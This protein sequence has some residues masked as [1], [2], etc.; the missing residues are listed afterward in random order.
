MVIRKINSND[1]IDLRNGESQYRPVK[2]LFSDFFPALQRFFL[3][4]GQWNVNMM[5]KENIWLSKG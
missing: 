1:T 4:E 3:V 2:L 5:G